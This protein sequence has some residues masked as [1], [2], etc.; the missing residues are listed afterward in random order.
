MIALGMASIA[1]SFFVVSQASNSLNKKS[2]EYNESYNEFINHADQDNNR[3]ISIQE[4]TE[5]WKKLGFEG[6]FYESKGKSQFPKPDLSQLEKAI[7]S[8]NQ[9]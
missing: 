7:E 8:Y 1:Y 9:K 5:A 2:E 3:Y 6:P 4:Q